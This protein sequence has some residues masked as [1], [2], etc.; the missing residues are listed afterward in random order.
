MPNL[1]RAFTARKLGTG[2][3]RPALIHPCVR[4]HIARNLGTQTTLHDYHLEGDEVNAI[5]AG[6]GQEGGWLL[7]PAQSGHDSVRS[8]CLLRAEG[9]DRGAHQILDTSLTLCILDLQ[10]TCGVIAG[11]SLLFPAKFGV[12]VAA[13]QLK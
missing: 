7:G 8:I 12:E 9:C 6:L 5:R 2:E 10:S 13:R 11:Q 1:S 3:P 4:L